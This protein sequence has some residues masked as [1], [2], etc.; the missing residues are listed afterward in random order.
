MERIHL[1]DHRLAPKRVRPGEQKAG[2][3]GRGNRAADL[4]SDQEHHGARERRF[5]R[6]GQIQRMRRFA[7]GDREKQLPDGE[8]QRVPVSRRNDR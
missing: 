3:D 8:V 5:D 4:D 6:R 2:S 1:G 7:G